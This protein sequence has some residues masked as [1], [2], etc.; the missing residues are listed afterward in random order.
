M[1]SKNDLFLYPLVSLCPLSYLSQ[2][3][4]Y[5]VGREARQRALL[6]EGRATQAMV[7]AHEDQERIHSLRTHRHQHSL[8]AGELKDLSPVQCLYV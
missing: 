4:G 1:F 8:T 3:S 7:S 2:T 6:G 5:L